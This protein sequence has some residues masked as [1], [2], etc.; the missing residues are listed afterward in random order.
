MLALGSAFGVAH[1]TQ[2]TP[3]SQPPCRPTHV[4]KSTCGPSS[5]VLASPLTSS[6][7]NLS[8][9]APT[10]RAKLQ[11]PPLT[12]YRAASPQIP[13]HPAPYLPASD[14][15]PRAPVPQQP[16]PLAP[17]RATDDLPP[18]APLRAA[19]VSTQPAS[20]SRYL[21]GCKRFFSWAY[22]MLHPVAY[23]H[24]TREYNK[25][26]DD[27][28][29]RAREARTTVSFSPPDLPPDAPQFDPQEVFAYLNQDGA[30]D[31]A[32]SAQLPTHP[33]TS[34]PPPEPSAVP[35]ASR[36]LPSAPPESCAVWNEKLRGVP[37]KVC[38]GLHNEARMYVCD[39]CEGCLHLGCI[40]AEGGKRP[41]K[42]PWF[43]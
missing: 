26:A 17:G 19:D 13:T 42:G 30:I 5:S 27:M 34:S 28:V 18:P 22:N 41:G 21:Q 37:C 40:L 20:C 24:V 38:K 39:R 14:D 32:A 33:T 9:P 8:T 36:D 23:R 25:M 15:L 1:P 11:L 7:G 16:A 29:R 10:T 6:R 3:C 12:R 4:E 2:S 31:P 43:C 35:A